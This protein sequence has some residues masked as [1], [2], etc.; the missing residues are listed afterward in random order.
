MSPSCGSC[1]SWPR[2]GVPTGELRALPARQLQGDKREGVLPLLPS[3][4][5][6]AFF[7]HTPTF[8]AVEHSL[9]GHAGTQPALVWGFSIDSGRPFATD[10]FNLAV[11][12]IT[13][14]ER[15]SF[16]LCAVRRRST[17]S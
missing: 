2:P 8:N 1:A 6:L 9:A 5:L 11:R 15:S 17:T 3:H 16:R 4:S 14:F 10:R 13:I 12:T 7:F